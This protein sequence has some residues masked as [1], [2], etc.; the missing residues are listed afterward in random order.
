M[1]LQINEKNN[2][3]KIKDGLSQQKN[4]LIDDIILSKKEEDIMEKFDKIIKN[5]HSF[6]NKIDKKTGNDKKKYRLMVINNFNDVA[7]RINMQINTIINK[8]EN[9]IKNK[10]NN[11]SLEEL[12]IYLD[13][14]SKKEET[15]ELIRER[16]IKYLLSFEINNQIEN[17]F[18]K[19]E[20]TL[21]EIN[22]EINPFSLDEKYNKELMKIINIENNNIENNDI[23][24]KKQAKSILKKRNEFFSDQ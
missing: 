5:Y 6:M 12:Q 14:I 1:L 7:L 21:D 10:D 19:I 24:E 17:T 9:D 22:N 16:S 20:T 13:E 11:F 18:N 2:I 23:N 8:F 4:D 15:L 3:K